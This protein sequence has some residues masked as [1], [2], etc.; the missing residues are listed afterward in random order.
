MYTVV[1]LI[2]CYCHVEYEM[3][4]EKK[5]LENEYWRLDE[6]Q[7]SNWLFLLNVHGQ[8]V[9]VYQHSNC[10]IFNKHI[11]IDY[12]STSPFLF[13]VQLVNFHSHFKP[14]NLQLLHFYV[15]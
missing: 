12:I 11:F 2:C 1:V 10:W 7:I 9:Y 3:E 13:I 6:I 5:G 14:D 15:Y 4:G 8:L